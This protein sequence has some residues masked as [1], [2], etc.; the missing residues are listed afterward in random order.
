M[1]LTS[2]ALGAGVRDRVTAVAAEGEDVIIS[3]WSGERQSTVRLPAACVN[4]LNIAI[5]DQEPSLTSSLD[6]TSQA[7]LCR[8]GI[9]ARIQDGTLYVDTTYPPEA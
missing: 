5:D 9:E 1:I 4:A 3:A 2:C 8:A 6:F 7:L